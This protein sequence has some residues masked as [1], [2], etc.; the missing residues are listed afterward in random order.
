MNR[1]TNEK[2]VNAMSYAI[3]RVQKIGG[4]KDITGIQLHNRREREHSNSNPDIDKARSQDN[5]TL[6]DCPD[7]SYNALVDKRLKEGYKGK[8]AIRKDAVKLCEVLFTSD[9]DF[10]SQLTMEQQ[11]AYF[12]ECYQWAAERFGRENIISATVHMD[13]A[14]PHMHVDFV[15]LTEDGRLSAKSVLGGRKDLQELQD[16][17]YQIVGEH[18]GLERGKRVE[19]ENLEEKTPRHLTT[20]KYKRQQ[21]QKLQEIEKSVENAEKHLEE[22]T[23]TLTAKE[24]K[25][26]DVTPKR[27]TGGFK[28]LD[29]KQAQ[30]LVNTAEQQDKQIVS[31]KKEVKRLTTERDEAIRR[32]EAAEQKLKPTTSMKNLKK[33]NEKTEIIR[34]NELMKQA[35]NIPQLAKYSDIRRYLQDNGL[36]PEQEREKGMQI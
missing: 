32:A 4:A 15:P 26:L 22:L 27:I 11:Q 36:L 9:N 20:A 3:C 25:R 13:E 23:A 35:L 8:R 10:F 33:S 21:E 29:A 18:Y 19:L 34:Q 5:Y 17:F 24:V 14:T 2:G 1:S 16:S 31:L 6:R 28:G 12:E 7:I 30:K